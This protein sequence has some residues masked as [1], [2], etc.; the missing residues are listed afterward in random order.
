VSP[1]ALKAIQFLDAAHGWAAGARGT[2]LRTDDGG[3]SWRAAVPV[4]ATGVYALASGGVD[5]LWLAGG[6]GAIVFTADGALTDLVPGQTTFRAP[7]PGS[8]TLADLED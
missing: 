5:S 7:H 8:A 2:L 4:T 6:G 3:E 1:E